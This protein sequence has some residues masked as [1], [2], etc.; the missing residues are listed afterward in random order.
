MIQLLVKAQDATTQTQLDLLNP[1]EVSLN[2]EATDFKNLTSRKASFSKTF[3]LPNTNTNGQFFGHYFNINAGEMPSSGSATSVFDARFKAVAEIRVEGLPI[4]Q[5]YLQLKSYNSKTDTYTAV[6]FGDEANLFQDLGQLKLPDILVNSDGTLDNSLNHQNDPAT[7]ISS[8]DDSNDITDGSVGAGTIIYPLIDYGTVGENGFLYGDASTGVNAGIYSAEFLSSYNFR[9]A[10]KIDY[11]FRKIL[12]KAGYS[13][14]SNSFLSSNAWTKLYMTMGGGATPITNGFAGMAVCSNQTTMHTLSANAGQVAP[15][16]LFFNQD[17][18]PGINNNPA[19]T[20]DVGDNYDTTTFE[21][22]VPGDGVYFGNLTLSLD[23][24]NAGAGQFNQGQGYIFVAILGGTSF[25][26]DA[27]TTPA[28][29]DPFVISF[30]FQIEAEAGQTLQAYIQYNSQVNGGVLK[31]LGEGSFWTITGASTLVGQVNM[32]QNLPDISQAKFV[33]DLLQ[34]FNMCIIADRDNPRL[35]DIQP[36]QTYFDDDT[37]VTDWTQKLDLSKAELIEPTHELMTKTIRLGDAD[38]PA[39]Y[40]ALNLQNTGETFGD[41]NQDRQEAF[42]SGELKNDPVFAPFHVAA[43]PSSG[44]EDFEVGG[45]VDPEF[46]IGREFA[47]DGTPPTA[48]KPKLMYYNGDRTISGGNN[49]QIDH[50]GSSK[51]PDFLPFLKVGNNLTSTSPLLNWANLR[52]LNIPNSLTNGASQSDNGFFSLYWAE[53]LRNIYNVEARL[54]TAHFY[55]EPGDIYNFAFSNR[56]QVRNTQFRVLKIEGYQPSSGGT[57]KVTMLKFLEPKAGINLPPIGGPT[58]TDNDF[59]FLA[60]CN[61]TV[62]SIGGGGVV[63]FQ[64]ADGNSAAATEPCCVLNG[65][66]WNGSV[67]LDPNYIGQNTNTVRGGGIGP[68]MPTNLTVGLAAKTGRDTNTSFQRLQGQI[69]TN[70]SNNIAFT[71]GQAKTFVYQCVSVGTTL[72]QASL[73]GDTDTDGTLFLYPNTAA[74]VIINA[75][76]VQINQ[77]GSKAADFGSTSYRK[78]AFIAKNQGG[79]ISITTTGAVADFTTEETASAGRRLELQTVSGS[80][81]KGGLQYLEIVCGSEDAN[82]TVSWVLDVRFTL[83]DF[84]LAETVLENVLVTQSTEPLMTE[85]GSLLE[86]QF[87]AP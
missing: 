72:T 35:L 61:L 53:F 81:G 62:A 77:Y 50:L 75:T 10:I 25:P 82:S 41:Y 73:S 33:K 7:V 59:S 2:F 22:T 5:G 71:N 60:L 67:C 9:P 11:V 58:D 31:V 23:T 4:L 19:F 46:L 20:F 83:L 37:S 18:G 28:Q 76:S 26:Q 15:T 40:N 63:Q 57:A 29:S 64:D 78:F 43:I 80:G 56:I 65:Y 32:Q 70:A 51:Y 8:F 6:V 55:L 48:N 68:G 54:Y 13:L 45:V 38:D 74:S 69:A 17:S 85:D 3:T 36:Y 84:G 44:A 16:F 87:P 42:V 21:Y 14:A 49:I 39:Y 47:L 34:R 27:I 30:D 86:H 12:N 24:S 79:S 52:P 66:H 1:G